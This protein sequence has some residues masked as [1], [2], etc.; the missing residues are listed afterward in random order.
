MLG[1]TDMSSRASKADMRLLS[2]GL[3]IS[4]PVFVALLAV[5]ASVGGYAQ[6]SEQTACAPDEEFNLEDREAVTLR[7]IVDDFRRYGFEWPLSDGSHTMIPLSLLTVTEPGTY[8]GK[9]F[10]IFHACPPDADSL[11][12][13]LGGEVL[14]HAEKSILDSQPVDVVGSTYNS[15]VFRLEKIR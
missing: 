13:S 12:L 10:R 3:D 11:W 8:E 6:E 2:R 4:L 15:S 14:M 9:R 7:V 1:G 5:V